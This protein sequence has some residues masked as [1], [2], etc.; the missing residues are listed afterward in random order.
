MA[1]R[2]EVIADL[3][4]VLNWLESNSS[5]PLPYQLNELSIHPGGKNDFLAIAKVLGNFKKSTDENF[6]RL[7]KE[8]GTVKLV[9][10]EWRNQVCTKRQV[11]TR[12]VE[13]KVALTYEIKK[14]EVPVYEWECPESLL[15]HTEE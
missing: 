8:F 15:N 14:T 9:V 7:T 11:G 13:E 1:E 12:E 3:R 10:T 4:T 5:V 2:N 6:F